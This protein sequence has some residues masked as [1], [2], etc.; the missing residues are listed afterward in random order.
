MHFCITSVYFL[1]YHSFFFRLL[2]K[3]FHCS[4]WQE[5]LLQLNILLLER[6]KSKLK[7][8]LIMNRER[9]LYKLKMLILLQFEWKKS[10]SILNSFFFFQTQLNFEHSFSI[11]LPLYNLV[12]SNSPINDAFCLCQIKCRIFYS[13]S[14]PC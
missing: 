1:K 11:Y 7:K 2:T 13:S 3:C 10:S 12:S 5:V 8:A 9:A 14:W 4:G 6:S